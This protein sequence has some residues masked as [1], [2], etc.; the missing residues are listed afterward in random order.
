M[1]TI[2]KSDRISQKFGYI[3]TT[4]ESKS[5][6]FVYRRR[7]YIDISLKTQK[8]QGPAIAGP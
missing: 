1:S 5:F 2:G 7:K 4:N 3:S 8:A 6:L